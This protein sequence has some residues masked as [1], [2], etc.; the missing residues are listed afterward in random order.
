MTQ[1]YLAVGELRA[2]VHNQRKPIPYFIGSGRSGTNLLAMMLDSNQ[3]IAILPET[4]FIPDLATKCQS[5]NDSDA[6]KTFVSNITRHR[7]WLDFQI[8]AIEL[9]N[10]I[11]EID[12]F[13]LRSALMIFYEL[14]AAKFNKQRFGEHTPAYCFKTELIKDL[15]PEARFVHLIR[16]GRDVVSSY[17]GLF[18]APTTMDDLA[19][20]WKNRVEAARQLCNKSDYLE[21]RYEDLVRAPESTLRTVCDFI[22]LPWDEEMLQYYNRADQR[23]E[24]Y[25]RDFYDESGKLIATAEQRMDTKKLL[26]KPPDEARIGR[27]KEQ[28]SPADIDVFNSVAGDLLRELGYTKE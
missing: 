13:T 5:K 14:Y 4:H 22:D 3:E 2:M 7:R 27:W 11:D 19:L 15:F 1:A 18:F 9:Q 6:R 12:P 16:D 17:R 28:L 10:R 26:N 24:A 25:N 8:D 23:L 20:R 21:I